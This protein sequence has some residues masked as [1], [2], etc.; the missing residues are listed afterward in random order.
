MANLDTSLA[1]TKTEASTNVVVVTTKTASPR[2]WCPPNS[3]MSIRS[4]GAIDGGCYVMA[5]VD[6]KYPYLLCSAC[7]VPQCS[8]LNAQRSTPSQQTSSPSQTKRSSRPSAWTINRCGSQCSSRRV[9]SRARFE[10]RLEVSFRLS[11]RA[12]VMKT[13]NPSLARNSK[14]QLNSIL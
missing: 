4:I 9:L 13:T 5:V 8:M 2:E 1:A 11:S 10:Y 14:S 12:E 7:W 3:A 6:S